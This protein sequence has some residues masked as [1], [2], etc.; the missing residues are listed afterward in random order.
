VFLAF[1]TSSESASAKEE[2]AVLPLSANVFNIKDILLPL[3]LFVK[4]FLAY[5][6]KFGDAFADRVKI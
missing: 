6:E 4:D 5:P 1:T 2:P 3:Y